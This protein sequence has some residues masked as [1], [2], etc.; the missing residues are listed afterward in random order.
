M[1][2]K[3]V[4]FSKEKVLVKTSCFLQEISDGVPSHCNSHTCL[5]YAPA[6]AAI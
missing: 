6:T 3:T 5:P 4:L 2:Y 1:S